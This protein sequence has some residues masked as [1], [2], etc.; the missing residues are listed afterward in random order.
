MIAKMSA[1]AVIDRDIRGYCSSDGKRSGIS[2]SSF[3]ECHCRV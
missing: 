2:I 3:G 1:I